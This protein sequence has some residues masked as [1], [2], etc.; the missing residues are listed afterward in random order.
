MK[1][2]SFRNN[3]VSVILVLVLASIIR[4][5][6]LSNLPLG[7]SLLE[8]RLGLYLSNYFGTLILDPFWIR[9]PFAVLGVVTL[10]LAY[11]LIYR[12]TGNKNLSFYFLLV[13]SF[14]PWHILESRISGYGMPILFIFLIVF[15]LLKYN[16]NK[17]LPIFVGVFV[18]LFV[19][20]L[21]QVSTNLENKL[22]L[23][24]NSLPNIGILY[25]RVFINRFIENFQEQKRTVFESID[26][27]NYFFKGHPRERWGIE[28]SQK[29]FTVLIPFLLIGLFRIPQD[30]RGLIVCWVVASFSIILVSS[31]KLTDFD[32]PLIFPVALIISCGINS[33]VE[34]SKNLKKILFS[35][36]I[37]LTLFEFGTF[38]SEYLQ[39]YSESTFS[40]RRPVYK[41]L[42]SEVAKNK[43]TGETVLVTTRLSDA[44]YFLKFNLG[45]SLGSD[46]KFLEFNSKNL[47]DK[48]GLIVDVLPYDSSPSEA[49]F[50]DDG[51]VPDFIN[52]VTIL[53]D[54]KSRQNI[55]LF[56]LK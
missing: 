32:L 47:K 8:V 22:A 10:V 3:G 14:S 50:T 24:R 13:L 15:H 53:E 54:K 45:G 28:E 26:F 21:T 9:L 4:F 34:G 36:V 55:Y 20:G 43:K 31:K 30:I 52:L 41:D 49:L 7:V 6:D 40:P 18:L 38:G 1:R 12:I 37:F 27:G 23:Q 17:S 42:A 35:V 39:G 25:R 29:L 5:W 2:D 48:R 16:F 19:L 11:K 56:R 51:S 33:L 46:Y 44:N